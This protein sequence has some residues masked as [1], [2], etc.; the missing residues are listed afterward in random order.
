MSKKLKLLFIG[1]VFPLIMGGAIPL[2]HCRVVEAQRF[3]ADSSHSLLSTLQLLMCVILFSYLCCRLMIY[4]L[5]NIHSHTLLSLTVGTVLLGILGIGIFFKGNFSF[6]TGIS[7]FVYLYLLY[8]VHK[9]HK[10]V[11]P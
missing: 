6:E 2:W 8:F 3:S 11:K 4:T 7:F 10:G 1:I 5:R 9:H